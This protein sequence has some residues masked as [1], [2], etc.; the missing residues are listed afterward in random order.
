MKVEWIENE[1]RETKRRLADLEKCLKDIQQ[2]CEHHFQEFHEYAKC[3]KCHKTVS[4]YY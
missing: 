2:Q 3:T 4:L 1:M